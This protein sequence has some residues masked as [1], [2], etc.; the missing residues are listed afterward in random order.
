[1]QAEGEEDGSLTG[2]SDP[3]QLVTR[4]LEVEGDPVATLL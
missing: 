3:D 2:D 1:V 4:L